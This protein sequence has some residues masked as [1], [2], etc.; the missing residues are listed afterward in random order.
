MPRHDR[1]EFDAIPILDVS[2]FRDGDEAS[3]TS[4]A[5]ELRRHL[6]NVGFLYIRGHDVPRASIE[7]VRD[8]SKRFHGLPLDEKLRLKL[9]RNF[10]GYIPINTSTIVTSSVAKVT[11]PNQSESLMI[12][13]EVAADA[14][15]ALAGWPLQGPN[16]WPDEALLP[17]F[18]AAVEA[19]VNHMTRLGRQLA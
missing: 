10:R 1:G 4:I 11:K 12:M 5:A 14:P 13:H 2:A 19:Y 9:D 3:L 18:R 6:E 15:E 7:Q 16:Q 17:G 8:A